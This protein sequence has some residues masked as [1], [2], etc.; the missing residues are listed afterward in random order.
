MRCLCSIK[1]ALLLALALLT[2]A[3]TSGS[4]HVADATVVRP[5]PSATATLAVDSVLAAG[6]AS[7]DNDTHNAY[8]Q[9]VIGLE[10]QQSLQF[11][12]GNTFFGQNWVTAPASTSARDGLGPTFNARSCN[13]C[14]LRD[15]RGRPPETLD[16]V[17]MGMTLLLS[18]PGSDIHGKPKPE[19]TYGQQ[20]QDQALYGMQPEGIIT[21][22]YDEIAGSFP[23][24][25]AYTLR[26]PTFQVTNLAHGPI[27]LE[28]HIS[29][30]L[31][32]PLIGLGLLDAVPVE[33][34][35][36]LS[37]PN[38]ANEDGISGRPNFVWDQYNNRSAIGR[39]GWKATE[40]SVLQQ[41]AVAFSQDIGITNALFPEP[42]CQPHQQACLDAPNGGDLE[43]DDDDLLKVALYMSA[44]A[45]PNRRDLDNPQVQL[46]EQQFH[47]IGCANCHV[48]T[49]E[50][51]IHPIVP[52]LSRQTIH[53][54]TDLLLHDLGDGLSEDRP[55]FAAHGNEWRTPPLWGIG[56]NEIVNGNLFYLHDGRARSLTEAILWHGG[57][58]ESA[59]E[60]FM[61]LSAEMRAA[62]IRFLE[63][64]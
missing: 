49:L 5:L 24:G 58:A 52:K 43:I 47:E 59:R 45:V 18:M 27:N 34:L 60:A 28:A 42:N 36:A 29:A 17:A 1:L 13:S 3:C 41:V 2:P 44:L 51:G 40:P 22:S 61:Q 7:I 32:P 23:D 57:E 21:V 50:T 48:A 25:E 54:Y 11:F 16:D 12:V 9:P 39:F 8:A 38:D 31:A 63:S 64:L 35:L 4:K 46:G 37:D 30:R 14:H 55:D 26:R 19:P 53:P 33:T 62:L 6:L 10:R 15:G 56:L 20:L